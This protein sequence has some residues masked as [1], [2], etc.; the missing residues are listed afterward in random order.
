MGAS[1]FK[2]LVGHRIFQSVEVSRN[3]A[4]VATVLLTFKKR[5]VFFDVSEKYIV[6]KSRDIYRAQ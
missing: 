4:A 1:N 6:I 3:L 5:Q 2:T